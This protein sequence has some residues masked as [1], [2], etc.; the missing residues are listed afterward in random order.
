M[1]RV[2]RQEL[3]NLMKMV[4]NTVGK[5]EIFFFS[6]SVFQRLEQQTGKK[7]RFAWEGVYSL[8]HYRSSDLSN[9]LEIANSKSHVQATL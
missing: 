9:L 8:Q 7:H 6:N 4:E 2:C 5:Q 1:K 3:Q